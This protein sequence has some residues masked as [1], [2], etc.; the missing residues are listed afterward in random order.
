VYT[1]API[2][3]D[4]L[5]YSLT[6]TLEVTQRWTHAIACIAI[7]V[8]PGEGADLRA[9]RPAWRWRCNGKRCCRCDTCTRLG[10]RYVSS[11]R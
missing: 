6:Y 1:G 5:A 10:E 4:V 3:R 8:S 2:A 9:Q 11:T 7:A